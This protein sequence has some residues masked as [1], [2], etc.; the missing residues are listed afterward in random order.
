M[1]GQTDLVVSYW[2][3]A[4]LKGNN[5]VTTKEANDYLHR[6]IEIMVRLKKEGKL[7]A[8]QKGWEQR[9]RNLLVD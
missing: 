8:E 6:A 4:L 5:G 7:N 1:Q 2:K 3:L 9:L